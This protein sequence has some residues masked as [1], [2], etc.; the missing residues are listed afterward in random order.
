M[1]Y[2]KAYTATWCGPCKMIKKEL[3]KIEE[4]NGILVEHYDIDEFRDEVSKLGIKTVPT[5]I[6]ANEEGEYLRTSGYLPKNEILK[7]LGDN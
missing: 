3:Q 1:N 4:E 2:I 5:L 7:R 6:Y